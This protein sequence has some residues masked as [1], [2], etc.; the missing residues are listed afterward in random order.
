MGDIVVDL[1]R[2]IGIYSQALTNA[3]PVGNHH[4]LNL[5]MSLAAKF[6]AMSDVRREKSRRLLDMADF[7]GIVKRN[8]QRIDRHRLASLGKF[9]DI[10]GGKHLVHFPQSV[11]Q[12]A[13]GRPEVRRHERRR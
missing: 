7:I 9:V 5:D 12:N 11:I 13:P 2:P 8:Y 3:V 4:V 10:D 1:L 6:A